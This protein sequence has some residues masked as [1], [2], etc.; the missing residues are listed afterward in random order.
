MQ[1]TELDDFREEVRGWLKRHAPA[2]PAFKLP[3]SFME[4]GT[5]DQ[6]SFLR[7]WQQ[8][9]YEAG[10]LGM[11]WPEA[12]GGGG[13]PPVYQAIVT[14]EMARAEV[15]FMVNVI[16]L[17]WAGPTI[18]KV[19]T[20]AQKQRYIRKILSGEE[21]WCQGFS[22]PEAGSD[23]AS[24]A[25]RAVVRGGELVITGQ[26]TWT[27]WAHEAS[28]CALLA[29]TDPDASKHG[30]ISY[31]L[32]EMDRPGISVRPLVQITGDAEF[33]EVFFDQ[34]RV[35]RQHVLGDLHDGWRIAMH[36]LSSERSIYALRRRIECEVAY[37]ALLRTLLGVSPNTIRSWGADGRIPEYRHPVNNYRLYKLTDLE[38]ILRKLEKPV[39]GSPKP[40]GSGDHGDEIGEAAVIV[41]RGR[42]DRRVTPE[43]E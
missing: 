31:I 18:L 27:S 13:K 10:Y 16:G 34:V 36:T 9:V 37:R 35:P 26:K 33:S 38:R 14:E 40:K 7:D 28:W 24:L 3:D 29:R 15:P 21:I 4:V 32:V 2:K 17:F 20:E 23:L 22:E 8:Q 42:D 41:P 6:F 12:Y 1:D 43:Q 11:S 19:G 30:G 5:E 25:T 39:S